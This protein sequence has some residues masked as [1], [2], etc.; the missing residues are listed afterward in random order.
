MSTKTGKLEKLSL[1]FT[2]DIYQD[3]V[4]KC[5][6]PV[7]VLLQSVCCWPD[8]E[9][10][11]GKAIGW[12]F[13][14]FLFI[15]GVFNATYILMH[16]K[17]ISEAVGASV[18]VTINFEALVRIYCI[19]R[20]R[21]V[22]NEILVKI[23]K[24]FWPVKAVDDKTQAHL[25]NKAVFAITVIS[26]VLITSIF[27][28]TFITTMPFLKYN[29]LIS[30]STFPFDWNKHFVYELIYIWQYFLNWYILFAVLAFDFF[31]VALVSM[32]AIQFSIWQ[33]VMR[34][35]LNEESKE[36]RRVI[37]G[38]MEN[39]MTD[40]EML[41]HCW[42]QHKLLNNIC[43]DMESAF[44]ITILLQF[45]VSTCAN[46]AAFL[47]MKVDS[48]QFS[49]MLSFS[50]GHT[51]QL[52]YYCYSGQELMYQSEQLSHAIYECNWHLSYDRDF[53]KALVLMLHKSQR[54]QCLTAAN[55]TTLDFTSFIRILRLTFS[56]Y[57]LLDNLVEDTA[58]NGI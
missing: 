21:R 24:Q 39:E 8:D 28:N 50:M 33:H 52:F 25:E 35:I 10:P 4:K 58:E 13:F 1:K 41:R 51:T 6:L 55:F 32:C 11:Y 47:T 56:F 36:Q 44:S 40:K 57:T 7:K 53:R 23:W 5:L 48:S 54:I 18:T 16:G 3:G 26:I 34:N 19:L 31:F 12:I 38:K 45:V 42:Q 2:Q 27:S 22:F 20:N 14:S 49:K 46:C 9:L 15:N 29:Q 17:D 43:D 37:F 30:K